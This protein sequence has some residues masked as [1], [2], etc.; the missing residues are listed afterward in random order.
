MSLFSW[1]IEKE[2]IMKEQD[3]VYVEHNKAR[4]MLGKMTEDLRILQDFFTENQ[5]DIKDLSYIHK[6]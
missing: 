6:K 2:L 4:F 1:I 5:Y 3:K